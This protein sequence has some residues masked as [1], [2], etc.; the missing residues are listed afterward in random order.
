MLDR[1]SLNQANIVGNVG[2]TP[3][4]K[5]TKNETHVT[6]LSVATSAS[7]A[8]GNKQTE[9]HS[10]TCFGNLATIAT[11]YAV[12]GARVA[13]SGRISTDKYTDN[14]GVERNKTKIIADK[15]VLLGGNKEQGASDEK[16]ETKNANDEQSEEDDLPF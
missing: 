7:D 13:V 12:K 8:Q 14:Q 4:L 10:I 1:Q 2:A 11:K 5:T 9:W 3:E 6:S 15:L 16:P